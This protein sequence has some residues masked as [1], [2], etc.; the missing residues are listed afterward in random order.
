ML[1]S[2]SGFKGVDERVREHASFNYGK[3]SYELG[4]YP[5]AVSSLKD[6]IET[7]PKSQTMRKPRNYWLSH[8]C[9]PGIMMKPLAILEKLDKTNNKLKQAYQKV[10]YY[11]GV[12]AYNDK[13]YQDAHK[14]FNKSLEMPIDGGLQAACFSGWERSTTQ[15]KT[16]PA[17]YATRTNS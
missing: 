9:A 8:C 1:F 17:P 6:F 7:Y 10:A 16:M 14:L 4:Y 12:N 2:G 3:L 5:A 11:S 15:M 13:Q